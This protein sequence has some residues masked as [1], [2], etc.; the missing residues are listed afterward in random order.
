ML[1]NNPQGLFKKL[2]EQAFN[3]G[4]FA[5]LAPIDGSTKGARL[6]PVDDVQ[7]PCFVAMVHAFR[8]GAPRK[9]CATGSRFD[10]LAAFL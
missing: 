3:W 10:G 4:A 2:L 7:D 1:Q 6:S 5:L 9:R 8:S